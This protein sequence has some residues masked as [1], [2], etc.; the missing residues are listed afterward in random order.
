VAGLAG[1]DVAD[2][3]DTVVAGLGDRDCCRQHSDKSGALA[4]FPGEGMACCLTCW[5]QGRLKLPLT[6]GVFFK[7][8]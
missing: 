7:Y 8:R 1:T 4:E 2:L 5:G 3:G 6:C